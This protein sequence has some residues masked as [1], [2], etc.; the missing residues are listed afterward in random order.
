MVEVGGA[1]DDVEGGKMAKSRKGPKGAGVSKQLG[2]KSGKAGTNPGSFNVK[3]DASR[4]SKP[5]IDRI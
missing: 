1:R 4:Q 5:G 3:R 2:G